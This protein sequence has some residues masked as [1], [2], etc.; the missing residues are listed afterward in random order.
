[1]V[2]TAKKKKMDT[3]TYRHLLPPVSRLRSI[4]RQM[5]LKWSTSFVP[6]QNHKHDCR[7]WRRWLTVVSLS[8]FKIGGSVSPAAAACSSKVGTCGG[9]SG[10]SD[11]RWVCFLPKTL[12]N[13]V[14]R[15]LFEAMLD[16][17][18]RRRNW[19]ESAAGWRRGRKRTSQRLELRH[20]VAKNWDPTPS[21]QK[22]S[23]LSFWHL[24]HARYA[25]VSPRFFSFCWKFFSDTS[26]PIL[27]R[28]NV[29]CLTSFSSAATK[30][31]KYKL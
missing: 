25:N 10:F 6:A 18:W 17:W 4:I 15:P 3:S 30:A 20:F 13:R 5:N 24:D 9:K 11:S 12:R 8:V 23:E 19:S 21:Q 1:M 22:H 31:Q 26:T 27:S 29:G 16:I 28:V 7:R 14:L 2:V